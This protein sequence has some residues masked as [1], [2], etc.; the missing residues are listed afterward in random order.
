[1]KNA[2]RKAHGIIFLDFLE[3]KEYNNIKR[4]TIND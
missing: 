4:R 3:R 1:M 2:E